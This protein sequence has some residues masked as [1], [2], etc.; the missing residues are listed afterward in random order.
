MRRKL[1]HRLNVGPGNVDG[2]VIVDAR[3][4][5]LQ[6][7]SKPNV[8]P[9]H[10]VPIGRNGQVQRFDR[11]QPFNR[12]E[13]ASL[14]LNLPNS[15]GRRLLSWLDATRHQRPQTVVPPPHKQYAAP[16]VEYNRRHP[17]ERKRGV[18]NRR[19][20][21][22]DELGNRHR[23]TVL[24]VSHVTASLAPLGTASLPTNPPSFS[25]R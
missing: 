11:E 13:N 25:A 2:L 12:H 7:A 10:L 14:L 15:A 23:T 20:Q 16:I 9:M 4:T 24:T 21:R 6:A 22:N 17:H 19:P 1:W 3:V 5:V 18:T 8:E